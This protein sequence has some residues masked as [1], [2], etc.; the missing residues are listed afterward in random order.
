M[1]SQG[2]TTIEEYIRSAPPAGQPHLRR[3][4]TILE[5]VAPE[6]EQTIK[7]GVPFFVEPRF[8]FSF[9]AHKKHCNFA[10]S[11]TALEA[12]REDLEAHQ[13][14][15]NYLQ[16]PYDEPVPED[17]VRRIAEYRLGEVRERDDDSFW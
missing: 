6:V 15:K 7:W 12:F 1:A 4:H 5:S 8:V 9:S 2:P 17:L 14:T 16:I 10:P 11:P 13:T 3:L